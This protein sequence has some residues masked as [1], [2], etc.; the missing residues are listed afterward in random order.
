MSMQKEITKNGATLDSL[1]VKIGSIA[2]SIG[3]LATKS[4]FQGLTKH[5]DKR[6]D[7]VTDLVDSLAIITN[8]QLNKLDKR[9]SDRFDQ[10]DL[11]FDT[12]EQKVDRIDSRLTNQLDYVLTHYTRREEYA[13][14]GKRVA[15]VERRVFA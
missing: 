3:T 12:L 2:E 14:L 5:M 4:E 6:F 11:R 8:D 7:E 9:L 15:K 10:V 1:S 13:L